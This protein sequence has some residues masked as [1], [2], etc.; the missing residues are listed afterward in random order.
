MIGTSGRAARTGT[1]GLAVVAT[2]S[3]FA[4]TP[5]IVSNDSAR[6]DGPVGSG[7]QHY[8]APAPHR[9]AAERKRHRVSR[10][11]LGTAAPSSAIV[12]G[13]TYNW[14]YSVTNAG[15]VPAK[16]AVFSAVLS[17]WLKLVNAS[18]QCRRVSAHQF[19]CTL[20]TLGN[21]QT[22]IGM[23][24]ATVATNAPV[25][26]RVASPASVSWHNSPEERTRTGSLPGIVVAGASPAASPSSPAAASP[27]ASPSVPAAVSPSVS[28]GAPA[29]ASP[30]VSASVSPSAPAA[31]SPSVSPSAPAAASPSAPP[32]TRRIAGTCAAENGAGQGTQNGGGQNGGGQN[33]G[34]QNGGGQNGGGQNGGG[35]N[36]GGQGSLVCRLPVTPQPARTGAPGGTGNS[37]LPLSV[38]VPAVVRTGESIPYQ[39]TIT[40]LGSGATL[41][42]APTVPPGARTR[43]AA[44]EC[45]VENSRGLVCRLP[46]AVPGQTARVVLPAK[47]AATPKLALSAAVPAV[48]RSGETIPYRFTV[49]NV[50]AA[51]ARGLVLNSLPTGWPLARTRHAAG[52]CVAENGRGYVCQLPILAPGARHTF[53]MSAG[54]RAGMTKNGTVRCMAAVGAT[55]TNGG[56]GASGANGSAGSSGTAGRPGVTC[57]TRVLGEIVASTVAAGTR[58][59]LTGSPSLVMAAM[60]L[61]ALIIGGFFV[62]L[63]RPRRHRV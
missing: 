62:C 51:P 45:V 53:V 20:G 1:R 47:V 16:Q 21:G 43:H 41:T 44:G 58:L 17:P 63:G 2:L 50:G 27:S 59:P 14:P 24:T 6:A 49:T 25:G 57:S 52:E 15:P 28:P 19:A 40:Q 26:T 29:A 30:S 46:L 31:A 35:Q 23:V 22:K 7:N 48:V 5:Q 12:A 11:E 42:G 8:Y 39:F 32:K 38:T 34:G 33:G 60:A 3:F 55:G 36:G 4:I 13:G 10:V 56:S 54:T 61:N 37:G 9:A 18:Q